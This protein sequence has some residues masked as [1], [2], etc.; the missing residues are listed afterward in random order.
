MEKRSFLS[1]EG[2]PSEEA[3]DSVNE[4]LKGIDI[5]NT[6]LTIINITGI[7]RQAL[8]INKWNTKPSRAYCAT[9]LLRIMSSNSE[10]KLKVERKNG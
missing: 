7:N 4:W 8:I 9:N 3:S 1:M 6:N 2:R 10:S 5:V